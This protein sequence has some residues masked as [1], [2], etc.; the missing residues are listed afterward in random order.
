M[1]PIGLIAGLISLIGVVLGGYLAYRDSF[2][3]VGQMHKKGFEHGIPWIWHGGMIGDLLLITPLIALIV[4]RY[5]LS[6]DPTRFLLVFGGC[7]L[8]SFVLHNQWDKT[9]LPE[10]H[11]YLHVRSQTGWLHLVYLPAA[12]T[13]MVMFYFQTPHYRIDPEIAV[14]I[15]AILAFHIF[16]GT[17]TPLKIWNP[18]WFG[19][20]FGMADL[21]PVTVVSALLAWRTY[22]II[23]DR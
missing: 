23:A 17:H 6:W 1:R 11:T 19:V 12:L 3:T 2:L 8:I 18:S 4:S 15:S 10:S 21:I 22:S 5:S 14:S 16:L 9:N 20:P 13:V 7:L